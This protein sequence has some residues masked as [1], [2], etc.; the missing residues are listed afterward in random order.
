LK[1]ADI[2]GAGMQ[3]QQIKP[4]AEL[5]AEAM[6]AYE[7]GKVAEAKRLARKLTDSAPQFG[8]AH[9]L[10]GLLALDVGQGK[11]AAESLAR[12]IAITPNQPI[13]H[14]AMGRALELA[15]DVAE[16]A[17]H[18]RTVLV[19]D[20][21]HAEAHARLGELLRR[22]GKHADAMA[23]CQA[24]IAASPVHAEAMNTL[25][26]LLTETG[27]A[28][29]AC[30]VLRRA[31]ELRPDW[32]A[33]LNNFGVALRDIGR[34]G[35][36]ATILE[37]ALELRPDHA[38]TRANL[39]TVYR[40]LG[41]FDDARIQAERGT[42]LDS[43]DAD[44]W[45]ELGLTR[46]AQNHWEGAA[47]AFER[48]TAAAPRSARTWYCLGEARRA[49]A[50]PDR[51]AYAYRKALA[52]DP[53]D[54]HGAGLGLA[55][56]GGAPT[57]D[58]APEAYVRQLF[59]D[60]AD[61]FDQALVEKLDY[62]APTVLGAALA[63]TLEKKTDLAVMDVGCGTG[64]AAPVLKPLAAR[65]DGVDLSQAMVARAQ[66]RGLYDE[67]VVGE[68]VTTLQAR[69]ATY[70]LV[71]AADVLVYLG[72]LEPVLAAVKMALKPGGAFAFTVEKTLDT[73]T[74]LLGPK[75]RYAHAAE[76]VTSRA[77]A[78]G[79]TIALLEDAITRRDADQDVPGLVV[80][81]T[82]A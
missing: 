44:A 15:G 24:A 22:A 52:V 20:A 71:V 82:A 29:E 4:V 25:G 81:L 79:F 65:L 46:Q 36:A 74:Y 35:D 70:D 18:Y 39:A 26:A 40:I 8:G 61:R 55:L 67:L 76:Y 75:Q 42:R 14:L 77:E 64:L 62:R 54:Q 78:A 31:L 10:L 69:A 13:L 23:H 47:A 5:F 16:A 38:G 45:M 41:R 63:R 21:N 17:L 59:D 72:D 12:A 50:Q 80:V 49:L 58:K 33:A 60:Y 11:R 34:G 43:R 9:Y 53:D 37:G 7:D 51:A 19:I 57:P 73:E 28:A 32:P 68:L 56:A 2:I 3:A 48:A 6:R 30:D 66:A 27:R 1:G